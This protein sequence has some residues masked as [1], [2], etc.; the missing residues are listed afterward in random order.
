MGTPSYG[1]PVFTVCYEGKKDR[2]RPR[3]MMKLQDNLTW[4]EGT[5]VFKMIDSK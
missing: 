1:D 4:Q 2:E 3:E 5:S